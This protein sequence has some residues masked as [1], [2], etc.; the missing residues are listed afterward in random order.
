MKYIKDINIKNKL[1]LIRFDYNVPIVNGDI[2]DPFRIDA[3]FQTI[4]Y[5]L[6]NNCKLVLMSHLGRPSGKDL[7]LSLRP[8]FEYIN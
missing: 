1:V 8:I 6:K 3:S 4:D 7:N 5:C 2:V